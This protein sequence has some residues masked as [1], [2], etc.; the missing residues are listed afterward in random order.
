MSLSWKPT[1]K[2]AIRTVAVLSVVAIAFVAV[3]SFRSGQARATLAEGRAFA[4]TLEPTEA[5]AA[6][7]APGSSFT[8]AVEQ[9]VSLAAVRATL[10]VQPAVG[11]S[12]KLAD[13]SGKIYSVTPERPLEPDR[14]YRFSLALAGPEE[15]G[16]SWA[17]QVRSPFRVTRTLPGDT[18][19]GV[20]LGSAIKLE[21]SHEGVV[22][23]AAFFTI[24]PFVPGTWERHR[25]TLVYVP[26]GGLRPQTVYTCTVKKGLGLD[27]SAETL[28]E[29][30]VFAF[31][32]DRE[33]DDGGLGFHFWVEGGLLPAFA[34]TEPP[35]FFG[36][37]ESYGQDS[38]SP[39]KIAV[40]VYRYRD[41][42]Q[43]VAEFQE[44]EKIPPWAALTRERWQPTTA[45]LDR[46]LGVAVRP[47]R[48]GNAHDNYLT[49]PGPLPAGYY[50]VSFRLTPY[51]YYAWT[52]VTDLSSYLVE[53]DND[54]VIWFN[55]L[56]SGK[57]VRDVAVRSISDGAP[58]GTSDSDGVARFAT[59]AEAISCYDYG[60]PVPPYY[61]LGKAPDGS[62]V[63]IDL[64]ATGNNPYDAEYRRADSYWSYL[65]TDRRPYRP[66][67]EVRFWGVVQPREGDQ[68]VALA[69]L[70]LRSGYGYPCWEGPFGPA[71]GGADEDGTLI[72]AKEVEV[73]RSTFEGSL[74]LP[75]LRP[76]YYSIGLLVDGVVLATQFLEVVTYTKPAYRL[77]LATN[78]RAV[79]AGETVEYGVTVAFFEGTPAVELNL[80]YNLTNGESGESNTLVTDVSGRASLKRTAEGGSDPLTL[81]RSDYFGVWPEQSWGVSGETWMRVF[82][83]DVCLR[84][85]ARR[86]DGGQVLIDVTLNKVDLDRLGATG[87]PFGDPGPESYLGAPV[88]GREVKGEVEEIRWEA[89]DGGGE[90]Y[91]FVDKVVKKTYDYT[92]VRVA[93]TSFALT[94]DQKG[95][96]SWTFSPE[97]GRTYCVRLTSTDDEGRAI[98][99]ELWVYGAGA[100][101]SRTND[102]WWCHLDFTDRD[103]PTYKIGEPVSVVARS[104][105]ADLPPRESG[106]L[107]VTARQGLQTVEVTDGPA[108]SL[109]FEENHIPSLEVDGVYFDGRYYNS[110]GSR[111]LATFDYADK[112]LEIAV[113]TDKESYSPGDRAVISVEV[114]DAQGRPVGAAVNLSLV[115]ETL[116]QLAGQSVD[117]LAALYGRLHCGYI[118]E[119]RGSHYERLQGGWCGE[120]GDEGRVM[121]S[122]FLDCALFESLTTGSDGK[123][124]VEVTL[125]DN[126]TSWRLTYQAFASDVRAG[127]GTKAIPVRLPF[128]AELAI[129]ETYLSGDEP[130]IQ[131][132]AY[133]DAL[134]S[135]T[136]VTFAGTLAKLEADGTAETRDLTVPTGKAFNPVDM[137]L[138]ALPPGAYELR[139][140]GRATLP[141]GTKVED[142]LARKFEVVDSYLSAD[143][144]DYYAVTENLRV[145][146]EPA[147]LVTLTFSD[148]GRGNYLGTLLRLAAGG[149]RV[150]MKVAALVAR[151]LLGEEFGHDM[152]DLPGPPS[153]GE[154][155][156]CQVDGGVALLPYAG[157][158]LE[159]T[160]KV[161]ALGGAGFSADG[162]L[163]YLGRVYDA[164]DT[165]RE[166][167]SV[168][169][170]GLA[171]LDQPVLLD[172]E[173]LA[174]EPDLST[175]E[176]LYVCLGLIETGSEEK[177][178]ALF[179]EVLKAHGDRVGTLL[180]LDV[181]R[182]Q[183]EIIAATSLAAVI[184]AELN[185]AQRDAFLGY[186]L[187]NE[188]WEELNLLAM[189]R[190]LEAA[191]PLAPSAEVAFTLQPGGTSVRLKPGETYT[192]LR[193]AEQLAG[194]S[195]GGLQGR[196][197]LCVSYRVPVDL[198]A[199]RAGSGEA[200]LARSYAVADKVT[201]T[202]GAGDVVRVTLSYGMTAKV[203]GGA[204]QVVDFLPSG[205]KAFPRPRELGVGDTEA[206]WPAEIAGQRVAFNVYPLARGTSGTLT[207][208]A[209]IV[210]L[211]A[212]AAEPAV[213][214]HAR[215]GEIFAV[216]DKDTIVIRQ[217]G[218]AL[219]GPVV[220]EGRHGPRTGPEQ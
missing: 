146:A 180:R 152:A 163:A 179:D 105:E 9:P 160:A 21:F 23:P 80:K 169:L 115:D 218:E 51:V 17:F 187:D 31:E 86:L 210:S 85:D 48:V 16:F 173:R 145:S 64:A 148:A 15:P 36:S 123:G 99:R 118:L 132:R 2:A 219:R 47:Q 182:D 162:L 124:T 195:F 76:D 158:D 114:R 101:D 136:T 110:L 5:D 207:Y 56:A 129:N 186:L 111:L 75:N 24:D 131:A 170:Y 1:R 83:K 29:D 130:V 95:A 166:R 149:C 147:E 72:L 74:T 212:F 121:Y 109:A 138:G 81:D 165:S 128:F 65:Y 197:G 37:Y 90:Y 60:P 3:F 122:D 178:R 10:S 94:T 93:Q 107:F 77:D 11:V 59:L 96:A 205:L 135:G 139:V 134:S 141:D 84:S 188:T 52:Q 214:V 62:E 208:Y 50:M 25:R 57:P 174:A 161:A 200:T 102:A 103:T 220:G 151:R 55:S 40:A 168:A 112:E 192:C 66:S 155:A 79:F 206:N 30:H 6:G 108:Y 67:E 113:K 82:E 198:A 176:K 98:G 117:P 87:E 137:A 185:L 4:V 35:S 71:V 43:F 54:T 19:S 175:Q 209:R 92:E 153:A 202:F 58:L 126:L 100:T 171:A 73:R 194:L 181:S 215:T 53:A 69:R 167:F 190:F 204:Y 189:A 216:T 193:T 157:P 18:A 183:E 42:A 144:V 191:L 211:G 7:V 33:A 196:V 97:A 177:A 13:T 12:V 41:A 8:L 68:E 120:A 91:E 104:G 22:D 217:A 70:E 88:A 154:L 213:L 159:L 150:D 20:L 106:Y 184:A 28:A 125:P 38:G 63:L 14:V 119:T 46:V 32:T 26:R 133:G 172:L 140:T 143:R 164:A 39:P 61:V 199:T 78:K 201:K 27:G 142:G 49:L 203:P 34:P 127:G 89:W 156:A 116:F 45:G 44:R